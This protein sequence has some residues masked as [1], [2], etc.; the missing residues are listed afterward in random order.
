[1]SAIT[2]QQ[3]HEVVDELPQESLVEV[4]NFIEFLRFNLNRLTPGMP[5]F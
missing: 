3:I 5:K 1:M 4:W 2:R